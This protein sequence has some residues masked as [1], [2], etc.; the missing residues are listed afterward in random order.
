M[1]DA[2]SEIAEQM[3]LEAYTPHNL[4][5]SIEYARAMLE[6]WQRRLRIIEGELREF[7]TI[8]EVAELEQDAAREDGGA[9]SRQ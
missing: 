8:Q 3:Q 5:R 2:Q 4:E 6:L 9:G 1:S 7:Q